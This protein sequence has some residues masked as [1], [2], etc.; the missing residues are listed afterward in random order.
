MNFIIK[1]KVLI[2]MLFTGLTM[3][4]FISYKQLA[5]ELY[6]NATFPMLFVQVG[7]PMEVDPKYMENQAIIPLEG[8]IGTLENIEKIESTAGQ[9]SGSIQV[10]Y[11][12]NVDLKFAYLKLVEKVDEVKNTLPEEFQVQTFKFDLEQLNNMFMTIQVRGSGGVDRVRQVTDKEIINKIKNIDGIAN[13]EVFGGREKSIEIIL[14]QD[15]CDS[16]NITPNDVRTALNNNSKSRTFAGK[17]SNNNQLHFVN[18]ISEFDDIQDIQNLVVKEQGKIKLKDIADI[19]YGVKEQDS[20]SRINGKESVTI[21]LTKDSQANIIALANNVKDQ[22]EVLNK[23]LAGKDIEMVIQTNN[24]ETMENNIDDIIQLALIGGLLAIFVLWIFLKNF[25]LVI[26]IALAIPISVYTAFNFFYAFGITINSLTLLGMALAIGMLLDNSVVVLE[27]IYRLAAKKVHPDQAVTQGTKEVWRSIFAA[28]LTTITV[29]LPFVFSTNFFI[30]LIGKHIGVSIISTLVVSLVVALLLI[31]MIT[32]AFLKWRGT[33]KPIQFEKIS[34]HN[35]LIQIYRVLLKTCMRSPGKTILGALI[36]FFLTL[37]I[38]LGVSFISS[39]EAEIKDL[40][41]YVTMPSGTTLENT[42]ILIAEAEKKLEDLEEKKDVLSQIYPEEAALTITLVDDYKDIRNHSIP[43]IK[44]D[45]MDRLSDLQPAEFSWDP[46]AQ[47]RRFGGDSYEDD[48]FG[49]MLGIGTQREKVIIKGQDFDKMLNQ[50][51]DVKYYLG[52]STS[53]E[54]IDVRI[55]DKRPELMLNFDKQLMALYDIPV[56]SVLSELNSFQHEFSSG[57]KFKQG[58]D[59]YDILIKTIGYDQDK[60]ERDVKDLKAL[61]VRGTQGT[62][63]ELQEISKFNFT[64]GLSTIKRTNQEKHLEVVYQFITEV[65][66]EKDLLESARLEV[67]D[68][69]QGMTLPSGVALEVVHDDNDLGEFG[70]LLLM[71]FILIYMILSSVF[72]SFTTPIVMMFSIPMAAIGSLVLL[73][74]TG[75]SLMNTNVLTGLLILLGIVVNNGIILIDYSRVLRR[76]GYSESRALMMAGLARVRPILITAITTIIALIPL[77]LGKAEYVTLIGVPFAITIIGGL[78]VSTLLTLVFIPTLNSGLQSSLKWMQNQKVYIKVIQISIWLIGSY[79]IFTEVDRRV[80]QIIDFIILII[81]VPATIYFIQNSLRKASEKLID[82]DDSL[83]I[84]IRNLVKIYDWDSRFMREWKS[85]INIRKRLGIEREYKTIKDFDQL[86]WQIPLIGFIIFFIYFHLESG[87]WYFILPIFLYVLTVY[88]LEPVKKFAHNLKEKKKGKLLRIGI[89][90][91]YQSIFW[92]FPAAALYL[93]YAK[94]ELLGLIIPMGTIW[95]FLILIKVTSD[96]LYKKKVNVNRIKGKFK[97]IRKGFYRLVLAI[98]IIGKKKIPFK[99][100]KG[101]SLDIENGMF[102]LLGPN[103]AG[104]ST[105]MRIIC[106]ILEQSYGQITI[107][108]FD[109]K[110][111]REELQG[112]IGYLPQEFGMYENMTAWDFLNYMGIL[113]KLF[114]QEARYKRIEYV[115]HAVHMYENRHEKIGSFSG[116]MKQRIGIA[117]ILLHLPKILVVD[118]PTAGLDPRERIRFRN[119]LVELSKE[120][121]VIFSTHIIEDVASSCNKV[122]VMKKGEV[123]YLGEPIKMAK[124]AEEKVWMLQT[125]VDEFENLKENYTIIHHMKEG[126]EIRCRCLSDKAPTPEAKLVK[127]NLE[128]AYLYLL[129]KDNMS[130]ANS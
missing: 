123:Q 91:F 23:E 3:L 47:G 103:G 57:V 62:E 45:I 21:S 14:Q 24:A 41:L 34:Y 115:L 12:K 43:S 98:P 42:D 5:V 130:S 2:A 95:Y 118:E 80:W 1:R 64:E 54:K 17:V 4:G 56:T 99:A 121:I 127:A 100:L 74:L 8:A 27:N 87:L 85:G 6:P 79:F 122:A 119:L 83:H 75:T 52:Q 29:F 37:L 15:I 44:N 28:T 125:S 35:R 11:E 55:P 70:F 73:I 13:A 10:S 20:Y 81:A 48:A 77:A 67:D 89:Q 25:R 128:D 51:N 9:Q 96:N 88:M 50:A 114:D 112:L 78:T 97:G 65:Q 108:G 46:P 105:L 101:V 124:I 94:Y 82:K 120:R 66:D 84:K 40:K 26:A 110:E 32:H 93:F 104:K 92:G 68:L 16:Y 129:T 60:K 36:V 59:E 72:E 22:I 90:F 71:A 116:G 31:P 39:Q 102:G 107:N 126:D 76:Q 86:I 106:G 53:I 18:V 19:H 113:K 38:S 69:I 33:N 49:R 63:F 61:P 30:G 109:V 117:Q 7:T 111:K 58:N